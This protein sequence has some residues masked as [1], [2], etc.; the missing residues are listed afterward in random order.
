MNEK[1]EIEDYSNLGMGLGLKCIEKIQK[2]DILVSIPQSLCLHY[3]KDQENDDGLFIG[4]DTEDLVFAVKLAKKMSES[5]KCDRTVI[6][7]AY[8]DQFK[9]NLNHLPILWNDEQLDKLEGLSV[10]YIL[11]MRKE[12]ISGLESQNIA[13]G[14]LSTIYRK[15]LLS[16]N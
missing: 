6:E 13:S 4:L 14:K 12:F 8:L 2:F 1:I 16:L 9:G 15:Q 7:D 11:K 10:H 5:G 3:D